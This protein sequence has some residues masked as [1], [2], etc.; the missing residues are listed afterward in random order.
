VEGLDGR[1][2]LVTGAG[3]GIGR[4]IAARLAAEGVSVVVNDLDADVAQETVSEIEAAGGAATVAPGSVAD[5]AATDAMVA[6]AE[7]AFGALDVV[8]NNAGLTADDWL[9]RMKDE[10]WNLVT[11]VCLDGTFNVCRSA[12][13]LLRVARGEEPPHNRKIVNIASINGIYG[14]AGNTNYSAAKAGVIGL[15]KALAREWASQRINVNVIAP[16]YIEGTRLTAVREEGDPF[17]IPEDV[18]PRIVGQ[19]PLGRPGTAADI[20]ALTAF[21][22]SSEADYITGQVI[23]VH[24]GLEIIKVV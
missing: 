15:S 19:I 9:H 24:G 1:V 5:S 17:G 10:T 23:E 16:G 4:G 11:D 22:A 3:R 7:Q 20:A 2:A 18:I 6:V 12:A 13:R 14:T 21:L 8:V